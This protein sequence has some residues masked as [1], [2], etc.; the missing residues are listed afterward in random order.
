M[1]ESRA[2][3]KY[4]SRYAETVVEV[5]PLV[6][7]HYETALVIPV[8]HEDPAVLS[9]LLP[10]TGGEAR[11]LVILVVNQ[12]ALASQDDT[13]QNEKFLEFVR[14]QGDSRCLTD[15]AT[16]VR[17]PFSRK[18]VDVLLV[19]ATRGRYALRQKEG[20]G[21]ARKMGFDLALALY[22]SGKLAGP[23]V[24]SSDADVVIPPGY[25]ESLTS[26]AENWVS[27]KNCHYAALLYPYQHIA[28]GA[29]DLQK[30]MIAVELG[31]RYYVL[32]LSYAGSPYAYHSLG[33]A[34]AVSLPHYAEVR[35]VPNRQ[36]GEDFHLL[37]KLSKL[38]PLRRLS[39]PTISIETRLSKRVPFGTGPALEKALQGSSSEV[40]AYHPDAF[41]YLRS[42][43]GQLVDWARAGTLGHEF[44]FEPHVPA[45][46][47]EEAQVFMASTR[48][49]LMSCPTAAHR[50]RRVHER[51][52]AL[53]TLQFVHRAHREGLVMLP[54][55]EAMGCAGFVSAPGSAP[56]MLDWCK[57]QES[58][59]TD[60][61]GLFPA[62]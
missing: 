7:S 24:G 59:L 29:R 55:T 11:Q 62:S 33:S 6:S 49:H 45:W 38:A 35:G 61:P 58:S 22:H 27:Q 13:K 43:L 21:R 50:E 28:S 37:A 15:S 4:L 46:V 56:Q 32:G 40:M 5:E 1:R 23:Y 2:A 10:P 18:T 52:D 44:Q 54:I 8:Y 48:P 9:R 53:K 31:F 17:E 41:E 25:V 26:A 14:L 20:V 60:S 12:P 51:F 34:L 39:S 3:S 16:L 42:F 47:K 36:A 19:D 30:T 57:A